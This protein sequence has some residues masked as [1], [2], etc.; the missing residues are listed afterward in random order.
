MRGVLDTRKKVQ[1]FTNKTGT[2]ASDEVQNHQL[3]SAMKARLPV[4]AK[5]V[6]TVGATPT[7]TIALQGK[8][9]NSETWGNLT[10]VTKTTAGTYYIATEGGKKCTRYRLNISANTN[11]TVSSAHIGVGTVE[12]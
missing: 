2:G 1:V 7:I 5:F 8:Q 6:M 11:V 9:I 10:S 3:Y 4:M 12:D